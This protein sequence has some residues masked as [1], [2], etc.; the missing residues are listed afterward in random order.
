MMSIETESLHFNR[1]RCWAAPA[2]CRASNGSGKLSPGPLW[3]NRRSSGATAACDTVFADR[4][5]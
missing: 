5:H 1:E 4:G 2:L 3:T